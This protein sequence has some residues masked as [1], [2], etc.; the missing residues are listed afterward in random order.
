MVLSG[1]NEIIGGRGAQQRE[2]KLSVAQEMAITLGG[3]RSGEGW[4]CRCPA[5]QDKAPSL[6]LRDGETA[7]LVHC[8]A[9]CSK[10]EL[11]RR[12]SRPRPAA[13]SI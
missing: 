8:F 7:L 5:H 3:H 4:V 1:I 2:A 12:S 9:G 10:S 13:V 11:S 6:S